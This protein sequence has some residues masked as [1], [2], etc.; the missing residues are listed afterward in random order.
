MFLKVCGGLY[1]VS[2]CFCDHDNIVS[3][4]HKATI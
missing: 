3:K 1:S 2:M 4:T